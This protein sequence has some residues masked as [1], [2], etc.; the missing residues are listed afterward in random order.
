MQKFLTKYGLAAHLALLAVAPLF[1]SETAI[2]W[3]AALVA[4]GVIMEPSRVG[5]EMLHDA[6]R[7]VARGLLRD[8]LFWVGLTLVVIAAIRALNTGVALAYDAEGGKWS[9]ATPIMPIL[10]GSVEGVG[11]WHFAMACAGL[12]LVMG[13]RH[14]LGRSARSAFVLAAS[15]FASIIVFVKLLAV[16]TNIEALTHFVEC[17]RNDPAYEGCAY[18]ILFLMSTATLATVF[19]RRWWRS[20]LVAVVGICGTLLGLFYLAPPPSTVLF[21]GASLLMLL[22]VFVYLR[23]KISK[24]ADFRCL[25]VYSMVVSF[26]VMIALTIGPD[27]ILQQKAE[28]YLTGAFLDSTFWPVREV[29]SRVSFAAWRDHPWLGTGLGSYSIDMSMYAVSADWKVIT[30]LQTSPLNGYWLLLAERGVVGAFLLAIPLTIMLVTYVRKLLGGVR[31]LPQ[32]LAWVMPLLL[33]IAGA[34]MM[35]DCSYLLAKTILP[36]LAA[37]SISANSF[38][39][40]KGRNV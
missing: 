30:S 32:P 7:R 1:L 11:G 39:K 31:S 9:L 17:S 23:L 21:G 35:I 33:I 28:P 15:F 27:L 6:R 18:G 24:T 14:A 8:P 22:Y 34:E 25:V 36:L 38:A 5:S 26:A 29:L 10:P 4:V 13:C 12:V 37:F 2:L 3:V 16:R 40:E 19:E 20:L